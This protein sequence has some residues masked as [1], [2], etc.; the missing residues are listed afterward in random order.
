MKSKKIMISGTTSNEFSAA[1]EIQDVYNKAIK[2]GK[3]KQDNISQEGIETPTV[4][5]VDLAKLKKE[6]EKR[7]YENKNKG[8]LI[9]DLVDLQQLYSALGKE[10]VNTRKKLR[11]VEGDLTIKDEVIK[12]KNVKLNR[13]VQDTILLKNEISFQNRM[14]KKL[15]EIIDKLV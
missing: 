5:Q 9:S 11:D 6:I 3:L 10:L 12:E 14:I 1:K 15:D 13:I 2:E 7:K 8:E 4:S